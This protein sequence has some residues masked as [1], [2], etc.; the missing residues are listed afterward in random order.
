MKAV[1]SVLCRIYNLFT[2][3]ILWRISL[4]RVHKAKGALCSA[5]RGDCSHPVVKPTSLR[6]FQWGLADGCTSPHSAV[7]YKEYCKVTQGAAF[8]FGTCMVIIHNLVVLSRIWTKEMRVSS[9]LW[10][11]QIIF[12]H[13]HNQASVFHVVCLSKWNLP[14]GFVREV[15]IVRALLIESLSAPFF[16]NIQSHTYSLLRIEN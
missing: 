7:C 5:V 4:C 11:W 3:T 14:K 9:V 1:H 8:P 16:F 13:L 15:Y 2:S 12:N 10:E 6:L